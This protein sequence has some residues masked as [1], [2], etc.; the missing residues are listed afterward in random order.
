[1]GFDID[2]GSFQEGLEKLM[3]PEPIAK[4]MIQAATPVVKK[5]LIHE[6]ETSMG[7]WGKDYST[8]EMIGS[9]RAGR[10]IKNAFGLFRR[11]GPTGV[12]SRGWRNMEIAAYHNYGTSRQSG[13]MFIEAAVAQSEAEAIDAMDETFWRE[14]DLF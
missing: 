13:S 5:Q 8:G 9:I 1:M 10:I 12:N 11:V 7:M 4:R 2:F 3:N 14:V 6:A